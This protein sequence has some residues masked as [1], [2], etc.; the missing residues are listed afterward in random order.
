M[1]GPSNFSGQW[2][3][4]LLQGMKKRNVLFV[5]SAQALIGSVIGVGIFGIP[6]VFAQSGFSVGLVHLIVIGFV[7]L[8]MLIGYVEIV[9]HDRNRNR[10]VGSVEQHLGKHWAWVMSITLFG[11]IWGA[12][13]AYIIIG[14]EF[15]HAVASPII[16]GGEVL[17]QLI[18]M[19]GMSALL[20][21]GINIISRL[22]V[23]F[24]FVL[25]L[26]LI[27]LM[28]GAIPHVE[29]S[30][31]LTINP[32]QAF[33]PFGVLV[34]AFGGLGVI[35]EMKHI[36]GNLSGKYL[37]RSVVL[38]FFVIATIYLLFAAVIVGVTGADTSQEAILGLGAV[39]GDWVITIGAL[40][41]ILSVGTSFLI[42]G[43]VVM[44][45]MMY[46]YKKRF[47]ASWLWAVVIPAGAFLIGARDFINVIGF[48]GGV[49]AALVGL[50]MIRM[51]LK[52]KKSPRM[53]KRSLRIPS[54]MM[55]FSALVLF[56]G[57]LTTIF[58]V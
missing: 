6:Y 31:L 20:I 55:Y 54:W 28:I 25:A 50:V 10:L 3:E 32:E 58:S 18:F 56:V 46:D 42:L 49:F 52:A 24:V 14:G 19:I 13:V 23:V 9:L 44:D 51:Y 45:T 12:M 5:R 40:V 48:T 27:L 36:L 33:L 4:V 8:V 29:A 15:M 1:L 30:N 26:L 35:P 39:V 21:G 34:F 7:N 41:G 17:Y 43:I 22:Q 38:G 53:A 47:F 57:M 11:G 37:R 16:G 2:L